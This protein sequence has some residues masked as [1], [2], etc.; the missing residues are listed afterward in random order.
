MSRRVWEAVETKAGKFRVA[1]IEG[2]RKEKRSRKETGR[3][4]EKTEEGKEKTKERKKDESKESNRR[5]GDFEC[6]EEVTKLEEEAKKLVPA[7][8]HK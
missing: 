4:R 5:M 3:K 7:K 1:E 2:R 8:F 6:R